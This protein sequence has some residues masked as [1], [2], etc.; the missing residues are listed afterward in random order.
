METKRL[1]EWLGSADGLIK[2]AAALLASVG[3]IAAA[4]TDQFKPILE[5]FGLPE[6][7]RQ[8]A[9]PILTIAIILLF[10]RAYHRYARE[11]RL[12][13]PERFTLVA[14]TPESLIGRADD[15]ER[16]LR[17]VMRNRIVL[18]RRTGDGRD[19][20]S[21]SSA[22]YRMPHVAPPAEAQLGCDP[23]QR[24]TARPAAVPKTPQTIAISPIENV[25]LFLV[26]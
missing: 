8:I 25:P 4:I 7:A 26:A 2:T 5:R 24:Q 18:Q 3:V 19:D 14:T 12:E 1:A 15:L 9:A 22:A 17:S 16:L 10:W 6:L 23:A 21:C 13:K 20:R 11:S